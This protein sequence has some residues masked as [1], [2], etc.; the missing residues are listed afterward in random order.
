MTTEKETADARLG[1][2]PGRGRTFA[3][4]VEGPDGDPT[5]TPSGPDFFAFVELIEDRN[6]FY[7]CQQDACH[8]LTQAGA[9]F[10]MAKQSDDPPG[11][12]IAGWRVK[13]DPEPTGFDPPRVAIDAPAAT[14]PSGEGCR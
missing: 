2:F 1:D 13:P 5:S 6:E 9:T 14:A 10:L 11:T 4:S 3:A 8:L 7:R 12:D